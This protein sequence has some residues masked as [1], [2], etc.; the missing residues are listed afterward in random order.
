[1]ALAERVACPPQVSTLMVNEHIVKQL[2]KEEQ[3]RLVDVPGVV[4]REDVG[5]PDYFISHAWSNPFAHLVQCVCDHLSGALDSTKVWIDIAAVNQHPSEQQQDDLANL[6][7]AIHMSK[8]RRCRYSTRPWLRARARVVWAPPFMARKEHGG[9][10]HP[11]PTCSFVRELAWAMVGHTRRPHVRKGACHSAERLRPCYCP[12]GHTGVPGRDGR[13]SQARV[14]PVRVRQHHH[15]PRPGPPAAA[16]N[17]LQRQG[18]GVGPQE[19]RGGW[20]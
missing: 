3:C 2:T 11:A 1:M 6:R 19:G 10:W 18:A 9:A 16:H 13:A 5:E 7:N 17:Q 4:P 12:P 15:H 20:P 14:V 8:V